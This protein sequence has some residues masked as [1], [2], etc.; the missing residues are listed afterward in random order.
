MIELSNG[1]RFEFAAASGALSFD[2]RG[3]F[4][5]WPFRWAGLIDPRLL[6]IVIKTVFPERWKGNLNWSYPWSVL[7]FISE[8]GDAI[9]PLLAL[10]TPH[11]IGGVVNAIGLTNAG[12]D[13]W[14][15]K[16]YST[17]CRY[18]YKIIFSITE[19]DGRIA[20]CIKTVKRLNGLENI[21]GIEYN[22]SCPNIDLAL[23]ENA[24]MV[25][26]NCSA[27]KEVSELPVLLKLSY[28][29]PYL[30]IAKK[31]EG[32]IEGISI[33]TVPWKV[34]FENKV[35]PLAKYGGG[36]VSGP[37]ARPFVWKMISELTRTT[38]IPVIG[39]GIWEYEDISRLKILGASAYH[40]GTIFLPYPWKP[41]K[42]IRRWLEEKGGN[43]C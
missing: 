11:L 18:G 4:W 33:N 23:L 24:D 7:K 43:K 42:Y 13:D 27:I 22:A 20:G 9:N 3:W 6:T 1:H 28:V 30:Q 29:Q 31:L 40:F 14:L 2:G 39:A 5:E 25:V 38:S 36:G 37:V 26:E 17:V 19:P 41:K 16:D 10:S 15:E 32:V 35:S 8:K 34:V 21:V 12:F